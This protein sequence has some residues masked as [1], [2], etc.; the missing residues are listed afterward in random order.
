MQTHAARIG[1]TRRDWLVAL[2]VG[3]AFGWVLIGYGYSTQY[4]LM[5]ASVGFTNLGWTY[6]MWFLP[7]LVTAALIRKPGAC[8]VGEALAGLFEF[9]FIAAFIPQA[10]IT[11]CSFAGVDL[12]LVSGLIQG[13]GGEVALLTLRYRAWG[14]AAFAWAG[15]L[16]WWFGWLKGCHHT[17]CYSWQQPGLL[18]TATLSTAVVG[19][20]VGLLA[21]RLAVVAR[22]RTELP[23]AAAGEVM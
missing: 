7:G 12:Y 1:W 18:I 22:G 20:A 14:P 13:L 15:V 5:R 10:P 3:L 8:L 17:H 16:S 21:Q 11:A 2:G 9:L 19:L 23:L 6:P 4:L